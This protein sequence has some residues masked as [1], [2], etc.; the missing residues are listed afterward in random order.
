MFS[1]Q[2]LP[3]D[4]DDLKFMLNLFKKMEINGALRTLEMEFYSQFTDQYVLAVSSQ[5]NAISECGSSLTDFKNM[6]RKVNI[7]RYETATCITDET[8]GAFHLSELTGQTIPVAMRIFLLIK[9]LQSDQ[10]NPE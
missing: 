1:P 2:S 10:S 9:T 3:S 8:K 7:I 6:A 4:K 5:L